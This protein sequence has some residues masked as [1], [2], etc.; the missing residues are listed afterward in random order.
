MATVVT[1]AIQVQNHTMG[2]G[3]KVV[4]IKADNVTLSLTQQQAKSLAKLI[5]AMWENW[6]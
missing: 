1:G 4:L 5:V 2:G 6:E 3:T